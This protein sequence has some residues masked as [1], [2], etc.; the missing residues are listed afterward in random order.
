MR[1]WLEGLAL[2][3]PGRQ[4]NRERPK[5]EG[6]AEGQ[7]EEGGGK[8][9]MHLSKEAFSEAPWIFSHVTEYQ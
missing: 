4:C 5:G 6:G 7:R 9:C 1:R 3:S 2:L 8:D